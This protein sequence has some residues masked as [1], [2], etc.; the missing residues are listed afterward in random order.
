MHWL[1]ITIETDASNA[2]ALSDALMSLGALSVETTDADAGSPDENAVFGEPGAPSTLWDRNKVTGLFNSDVD[3]ANIVEEA[4]RICSLSE[5]LVFTHTA[6]AEQ[7]W[8]K[9]TQEQFQPIPISDRLWITP[10]WHSLSKP[11]AICLLLDPGLAFGTGSHPTTALCLRWLDNHIKGGESVLDY[12][13]GSGILTIAALKLG[14]KI[15]IGV[16]IDP[17]AVEVSKKNA[18]LNQVSAQFYTANEFRDIQAD[19]VVA[20]ILANPLKVLAPALAKA[21]VKNG[22]VVLSGILQEQTESVV[23]IYSSWFNMHTVIEKDGWVC[24]HGTKTK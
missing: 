9:L 5:T 10:T 7:D 22:A 1:S 19:I 20:N 4:A 12:G 17:Q 15:G 6:I 16:D 11:D 13:C 3:A 24:L 8:V 23:A 14:A 21:T 2:E 18:Q